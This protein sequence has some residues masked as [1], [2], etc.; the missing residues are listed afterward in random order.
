M[1]PGSLNGAQVECRS[2]IKRILRERSSGQAG[3]VHFVRS[4]HLGEQP[5]T[6]PHLLVA[7][8]DDQPEHTDLTPDEAYEIAHPSKAA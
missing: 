5:E 6:L 8:T 1:V 3:T 4:D 7:E 2:V